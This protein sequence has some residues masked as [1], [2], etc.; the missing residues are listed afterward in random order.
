M[1]EVLTEPLGI[2]SAAFA[3]ASFGPFG[4]AVQILVDAVVGPEPVALRFVT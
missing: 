2:L 4:H 3:A 1:A